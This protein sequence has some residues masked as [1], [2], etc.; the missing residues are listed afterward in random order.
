MIEFLQELK[1]YFDIRRLMDYGDPISKSICL[2]RHDIDHDLNKALQLGKIEYSLGIQATYFVLHDAK[3]Y[4][5]NDFIKKCLDLQNMGHEIGFHNNIV[6]TSIKTG[7][8]IKELFEKELD[9]LRKNNINIFGTAAHGDTVC[10]NLNYTNYEIFKECTPPYTNRKNQ[11]KIEKNVNKVIKKIKRA[12]S[13]DVTL[14]FIQNIKFHTL[15][16]KDYGLYEAYFLHRDF[17]TTECSKTW[18]YIEGKGDEWDTN[19]RPHSPKLTELL[20]FL[21]KISKNNIILQAL[22]HPNSSLIEV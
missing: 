8:N 16:L 7:H 21:Y 20:P 19:F 6:T 3:Y 18:R 5:N 2:L 9:Y 12:G 10:R 14:N 4:G 17:Y 1:E 13:P 15:S 11:L 22:F